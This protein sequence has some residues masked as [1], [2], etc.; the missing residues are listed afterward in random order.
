MQLRKYK[1]TIKL[2]CFMCFKGI[3]SSF[4]RHTTIKLFKDKG[5]SRAK[6]A[7]NLVLEK[8]RRV[9]SSPPGVA[10]VN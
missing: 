7:L 3:P 5:R 9:I 10:M 6:I 2:Y 1:T 4:L 8:T